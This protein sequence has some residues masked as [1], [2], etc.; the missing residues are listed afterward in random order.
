MIKKMIDGQAFWQEIINRISKGERTNFFFSE[1]EALF[2]VGN[3]KISR[4]DFTGGV[5]FFIEEE[6]FYR[7]YYFLEKGKIPEVLPEYGKPMILEEVLLAAKE[8]VPSEDSWQRIGFKPYLQRKRMYLAS[9]NITFEERKVTFASEEMLEEIF[10]LMQDSFEPYS[11]ALPTKEELLLDIQKQNVLISCKDQKLL[12]FLHFGDIKQG[13]MLWHIAV[14]PQARG[15][16]IGEGLVKDWFTAQRDI[17]K[18]FLLWV[19]TDNP[20]ALQ[21]YE[22]LG[23][24]PDGRVAPVMIKT[25]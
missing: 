17:A 22:K 16:G 25:T 12:G 10:Q 2:F 15:L 1:E 18:K 9:K 13:S 11:S 8:R 4:V 23:F 20:P 24:L 14:M 3:K 7:L 19:R 6:S 5:Y 21:M